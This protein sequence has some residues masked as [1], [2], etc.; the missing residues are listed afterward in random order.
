MP[1]LGYGFEQAKA[2]QERAMRSGNA[3]H[4]AVLAVVALML[5]VG[6]VIQSLI[7]V[8]VFGIATALAGLSML[9]AVGRNRAVRRLEKRLQDRP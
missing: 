4:G 1:E 2:A 9:R 3:G 6:I 8:I 5:A 7:V